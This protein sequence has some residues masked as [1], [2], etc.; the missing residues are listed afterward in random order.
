MI[1][2]T[3]FI[4]FSNWQIDFKIYGSKQLYLPP[5]TSPLVLIA[6]KERVVMMQ[7]VAEIP[8]ITSDWPR[9]NQVKA[10]IYVY[11]RFKISKQN[12]KSTLGKPKPMTYYIVLW[13]H[14][15]LQTQT[16]SLLW[17]IANFISNK[18]LH[19][20]FFIVSDFTL[21]FKRKFAR[22]EFLPKQIALKLYWGS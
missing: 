14:T 13:N 18:A 5:F 9:I 7:T 12:K 11:T 10:F 2:K 15:I 21:A 1:H 20:C 17:A 3:L 19:K 16:S 4:I 8:I 22:I 6:D